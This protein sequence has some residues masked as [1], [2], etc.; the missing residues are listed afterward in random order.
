MQGLISVNGAMSPLAEAKISVLDRGFLFG[1][2]V[3]ETI[4]A[5][6]GHCLNFAEHC[7]RLR[8]SA[9]EFRIAIPWSNAEL[10]FEIDH[11]LQQLAAPKASIRLMVSRG[12]GL[13]L[14]I[15]TPATSQRFI[16]AMPAPIEAESLYR[17][18]I[19]IKRRTQSY[20]NRGYHAKTPNY[21]ASIVALA[22]AEEQGFSDVLWTNSERELTECTTANIFFIGR[23]GDAVEIATPPAYSGILAGITRK[24]MLKLLAEAKIAASERVIYAEEIPRFDEAFICST[25]RGLVPIARIDQHRL[26]SARSE[27]TFRQLNRLYATWAQLQLGKKLDWASGAARP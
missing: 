16:F 10:A 8:A 20:T 13:G 4:V 2:S 15:P 6:D 7:E 21:L 11:L 12:I 22:E 9:E 1:D 19:S 23:D 18:G 26:H 17:D 27:S 3:F 14:R 5:F 25:V 24:T